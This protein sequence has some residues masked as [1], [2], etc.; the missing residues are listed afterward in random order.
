MS[1]EA[2]REAFETYM[3]ERVGIAVHC[4][5]CHARKKPIGRSGPLGMH[6]CD[7]ECPGYYQAPRPGSLWPGET[8]S[9]FGY[10][11]GDDG[12]TLAP[13]SDLQSRE[14]R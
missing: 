2:M 13:P 10:P 9:E 1:N 14:G 8:E 5:V 6:L 4:V 11:C 7:H 12:T 3:S